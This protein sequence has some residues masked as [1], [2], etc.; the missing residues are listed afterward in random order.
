MGGNGGLRNIILALAVVAVI[1]AAIGFTVFSRSRT[2]PTGEAA[3][4][5]LPP[6][7]LPTSPTPVNPYVERAKPHPAKTEEQPES[8]G[9]SWGP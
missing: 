6:R 2:L 3:G 4:V 9:Q 5:M 8:G 7:N 1:V